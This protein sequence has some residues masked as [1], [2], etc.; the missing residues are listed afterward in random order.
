MSK[1]KKLEE[2]KHPQLDFQILIELQASFS[3]HC[4]NSVPS[5]EGRYARVEVLGRVL[6]FFREF[7]FSH[8]HEPALSSKAGLCHYGTQVG[9]KA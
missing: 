6:G 9:R 8:A 5:Q 4:S 7:L 3:E 1:G 2:I